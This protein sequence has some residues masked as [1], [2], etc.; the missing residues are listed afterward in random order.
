LR[1]AQ[2]SVI[3]IDDTGAILG[4]YR[5]YLSHSGQPGVGDFFFK[6]LWDKQ[7]DPKHCRQVQITPSSTRGFDEFPDDP[8]LSGFDPS[9]RKF[10]AIASA[11]SPDVLNASDTDWWPVRK[12]LI[13]NGVRIQFLCPELMTK[14]RK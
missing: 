12:A 9:D 7:W 14:K 4:E 2:Q 13:R 5:T 8:E 3:L 6:W 11:L 1:Q 10:V